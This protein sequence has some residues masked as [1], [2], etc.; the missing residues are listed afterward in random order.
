M[1]A[2]PDDEAGRVRDAAAP[3]GVGRW[4]AVEGG[5]EVADH[6]AELPQPV[7]GAEYAG[8]GACGGFVRVDLAAV[9]VEHAR[10][11]REAGGE[12]RVDGGGS[13]AGGAADGVTG[14]YG[15]NRRSAGSRRA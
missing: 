15:R 1:V 3:S 14:A 2:G 5:T 4:N 12:Q 13:G 8:P 9:V 11:V 6:A 10:G 7:V